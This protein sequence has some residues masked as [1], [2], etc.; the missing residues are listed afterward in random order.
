MPHP[1]AYLSL[2]LA[3]APVLG[4]DGRSGSP[5]TLAQLRVQQ[6]IIVRIPRLP[7]GRQA[8]DAPPIRWEEKKAPKCL[9]MDE[10]QGA[11]LAGRNSID[12]IAGG[13]DRFRAVLDDDC[14]P[15]TAS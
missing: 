5:R 14:S 6:R 10:L 12:L 4:Q 11:S 3:A 13:E 9:P 15:I 7:V 8:L 1:L 2:F